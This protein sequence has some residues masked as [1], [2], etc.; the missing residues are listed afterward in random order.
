MAGGKIRRRKIL[1]GVIKIHM[2]GEADLPDPL[3]RRRCQLILRLCGR[4]AGEQSMHMIVDHRLSSV[5]NS[6]YSTK[7]QYNQYLFLLFR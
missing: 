2:I 5:R 7:C 6:Y 4:V 3:L 1:G